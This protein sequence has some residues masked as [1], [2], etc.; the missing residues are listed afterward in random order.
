MKDRGM[1]KVLAKAGAEEIATVYLGET[2]AGRPVEFVESVQPP[3]PREEKWVLII[4]TLCGCPGGCRFCDAGR[5]YR[6]KLSAEEMIAQID[7]MVKRRYPDG[8]VPAWK[9]K[10]QLARMGEP[11]FN[12]SVLD[13]LER[14]PGL[15]DAPGL[16]PALSTIAPAGAGE[17]F[18][19]LLDIKKRLYRRS[20]QLQFSIHTT[21]P[22]RRD[23]LMPPAKWDL[24]AI[25]AYG[26][27]F[28]DRGGRKLTLNFA[29]AED[30]PLD[31][32]VLLRHFSPDRYLVK[33]TPVNPT[34]HAVEN[35]VSSHI[36]PGRENYEVVDSLGTAGYE[37]LL[38]IGE[39][40]E[41]HIGSNCG[42]YINRYL[43]EGRRLK[44]GYNYRVVEA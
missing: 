13:V 21:D 10:V 32:G 26:D 39:P 5:E 27:R 31:P 16:L 14:L 3:I 35:G 8:R 41:N 38:S 22:G 36:V 44:A 25:A 17:F 33:I 43:E 34:C 12:P 1:I 29:L 4:S 42:Q 37:V 24:A 11:A 7:Y 19:S 9:F 2:E 18:E 20:F 6:G 30:M 40:E 15:Y 23:W 28:Y